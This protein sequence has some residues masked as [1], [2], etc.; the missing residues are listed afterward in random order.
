[1]ETL[2][3]GRRVTTDPLQPPPPRVESERQ[4]AEDLLRRVDEALV[5]L[6]QETRGLANAREQ[7]RRRQEGTRR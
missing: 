2:T 3:V 4:A 6:R 5:R 1:V 7:Y